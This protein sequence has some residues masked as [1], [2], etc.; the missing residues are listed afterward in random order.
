MRNAVEM[1]TA[2]DGAQS[3]RSLHLQHRHP[4]GVCEECSVLGCRSTEL[5]CE[6]Q[7]DPQAIQVHSKVCEEPC[8]EEIHTSPS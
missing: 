1:L 5:Q 8:G 4:L 3:H 7:R 6:F 2:N